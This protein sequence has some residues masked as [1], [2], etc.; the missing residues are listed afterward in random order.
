MKAE[1]IYHDF[2][3]TDCLM[4][5][6]PAHPNHYHTVATVE[7]PDSME[8]EGALSHLFT[9][10]NIGD[11]AG[12]HVRCMSVGDKVRLEGRGVWICKPIGWE[13]IRPFV[14]NIASMPNDR[15]LPPVRG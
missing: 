2:K 11:K 1:I 13:C 8:S 3:D 10:F 5:G 4:F 12:M 15:D 6:T 9:Q 7:L 14:G